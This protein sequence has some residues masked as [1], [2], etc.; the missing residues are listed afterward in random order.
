MMNKRIQAG[1]TPY[2]LPQPCPDCCCCSNTVPVACIGTTGNCIQGTARQ[3]HELHPTLHP[4]LLLLLLLQHCACSLSEARLANAYKRCQ[5]QCHRL[6]RTLHLQLLLSQQSVCFAAEAC[7]ANAC[8][9]NQT[10]CCLH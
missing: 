5:A 4:M 1:Q 6:P 3:Y 10:L 9:A 2:C 8:Q 7:R